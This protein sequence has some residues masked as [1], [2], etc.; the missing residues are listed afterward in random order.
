[1]AQTQTKKEK[2][3]RPGLEEKTRQKTFFTSVLTIARGIPQKNQMEKHWQDVSVNLYENIPTTTET[4]TQKFFIYL[5]GM[6]NHIFKFIFKTP[7]YPFAASLCWYVYISA[8][9]SFLKKKYLIL[10]G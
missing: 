2:N 6:S 10:Q 9:H 3:D 4:M 5:V 1:M 7:Q 8:S